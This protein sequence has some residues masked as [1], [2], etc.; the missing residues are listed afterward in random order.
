MHAVMSHFQAQSLIMENYYN[1]SY[2]NIAI[3]KL[4]HAQEG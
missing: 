4:N 3:L 2:P 1:K